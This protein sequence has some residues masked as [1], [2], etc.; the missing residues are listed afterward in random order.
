MKKRKG[1]GSDFDERLKDFEEEIESLGKRVER[2]VED[3]EKR[4]KKKYEP[5]FG[6]VSAPQG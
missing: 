2:K 6:L 1:I 3:A 5:K 4:F